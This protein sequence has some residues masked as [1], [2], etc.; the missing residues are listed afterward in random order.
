MKVTNT[1]HDELTGGVTQ[2]VVLYDAAGHVVGGDTGSSDNVPN[3]LPA[4]M[5]YREKWTGIP[6]LSV[7]SRAV[8]TMWAA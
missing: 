8:Y 1:T 2:Q 5:S 3:S 7:A 6:A 4:G